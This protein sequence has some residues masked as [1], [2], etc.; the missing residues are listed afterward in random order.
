M[1]EELDLVLW[2]PART[3]RLS[4][5]PYDEFAAA[6]EALTGRSKW[7]RAAGELTNDC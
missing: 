7:L 6:A 4:Q 2:G 1:R 5:W 3:N